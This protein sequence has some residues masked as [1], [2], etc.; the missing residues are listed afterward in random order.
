MKKP[1]QEKSREGAS[2]NTKTIG[3]PHRLKDIRSGPSFRNL[4]YKSISRK[5]EKGLKKEKRSERNRSEDC[6]SSRGMQLPCRITKADRIQRR[7]SRKAKRKGSAHKIGSPRDQQKR[8]GP[9]P[10]CLRK[11]NRKPS[12][13]WEIV[14]KENSKEKIAKN[15]S[16]TGG[17]TSGL[18]KQASLNPEW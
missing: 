2:R 11:E 17:Q 9:E 3:G 15:V 5:E 16:A 1:R 10:G 18:I 8:R 13:R 14:K 7:T 6:N 12:Y 4:P